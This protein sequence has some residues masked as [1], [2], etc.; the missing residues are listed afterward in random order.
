MRVVLLDGV[1]DGEAF[2]QVQRHRL[3]EVNVFAGL[4]GGNRDEGMPVGRGGDDDGVEV[5][6]LQ[7]FAE[8][9]VAFAGVL[10]LLHHGVPAGLPDIA[11]AG[12]DDIRMFGAC[13]QVG[14]AH[15][16]A[17]DEA[18]VDA[19][20]RAGCGPGTR[21]RG[22]GEVGCGEPDGGDGGSLLQEGTA[23]DSAVLIHGGQ[24]SQQRPRFP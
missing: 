6:L 22:S 11:G 1:A 13:A 15:A 5:R 20:V 14:P 12:D 8:V 16:A 9:G 7:Q 4:A 10:E 17:A 21:P 19:A 23:A 18:K 2:R 24:S 3:L